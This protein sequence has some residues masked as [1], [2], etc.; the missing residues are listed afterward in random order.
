M[1]S[2]TIEIP[3]PLRGYSTH[4]AYDDQP[5]ETSRYL[6]NVRGYDPVSG[7]RRG[8]QRPGMSKYL[9]DQVNGSE[10]IQHV[11]HVTG[12]S[13]NEAGG[14]ICLLNEDGGKSFSLYNLLGSE[15]FDDGDETAYSQEYCTAANGKFYVL[16]QESGNLYLKRYS[17]GGTIDW[18]SSGVSISGTFGGVVA[19][20]DY[21]Y[22]ASSLN[23]IMRF[24]E[25]DGSLDT[26]SWFTPVAVSLSQFSSPTIGISGGTIALGGEDAGQDTLQ[27][28]TIDTLT[29]S[30]K[31]SVQLEITGDDD[32]AQVLQITSDFAGGFYAAVDLIPDNPQDPS[33]KAYRISSSSSVVWEWESDDGNNIGAVGIGY[34]YANDR[35]LFLGYNLSSGDEMVVLAPSDGA[36]VSSHA[37]AVISATSRAERYS[38]STRT[39][40]WCLQTEFP[41]ARHC[42]STTIRSQ[43]SGRAVLI[44]PIAGTLQSTASWTLMQVW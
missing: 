8:G 40:Q 33:A 42:I 2:Q 24:D 28:E 12:V 22:V 27:F 37:V 5:Q 13:I 16:Y 23:G 4:E 7:R 39:G 17:S 41:R 6:V 15:F 19:D 32:D 36:F 29:A 3:F 30:S 11:T 1:K 20:A 18:T 35:V 44:A 43:K 31:G 34:D 21:I 10:S 9:A 14:Q 26:T 25:S 38:A